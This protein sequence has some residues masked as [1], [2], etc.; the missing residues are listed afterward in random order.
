MRRR[1]LSAALATL[2]LAAALGTTATATAAPAADSPTA[3]P[4]CATGYVC[5]HHDG[6]IT[7]V[8]EGDD[9]TFDPA[10]KLVAAVNSTKTGYCLTGS[11][12]RGLG[13]GETW[14]PASAYALSRLAPSGSGFCLTTD[15]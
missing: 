2:T 13:P 14:E 10:V 8:P 9:H 1:R 11:F 5:V 15:D 7:L 3:A 12:N 4:L 6:V